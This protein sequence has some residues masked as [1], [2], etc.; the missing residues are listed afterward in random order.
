MNEVLLKDLYEYA[1]IN[2]VP[3]IKDEG[4]DKL[5]EII[6]KINAKKILEIGT[7]IAY[8]SI[9][10][11]LNSDAYIDTIERNKKMY[12]LA[13]DNVKKYNLP[14]RIK[15]FNE[16]ALM[17][18]TN[19]LDKDYDLIF[20]D[21]AK[22]QYRKFFLKFSPLL[23]TGGIVFTDNLSFHGMVKKY[24]ENNLNDVSKDLKALVRKINDFNIWLKNYDEFDTEF[25]D[26]GDGIAISIKK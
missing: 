25:I 11:A 26:I 18:D 22:A 10:M 20:I 8:S 21:A 12:D 15:I 13:V 4:L 14:S 17:I 24:Q 6:K 9:C 5:I 7:A 1:Q 23:R 2:N 3:I 19:I 16:D